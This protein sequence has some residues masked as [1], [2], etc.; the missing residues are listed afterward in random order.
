LEPRIS[1][2]AEGVSEGW[3]LSLVRVVDDQGR[4]VGVQN[5]QEWN[6]GSGELVFGLKLQPDAS[7]VDCTFAL[8]KSR[9]F[10]FLAR[11]TFAS[12]PTRN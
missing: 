5:G 1:V 9:F 4:E 3:R 2:R 12:P 7:R 11:P 8:H 10:E 6:W